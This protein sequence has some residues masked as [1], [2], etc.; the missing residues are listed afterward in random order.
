MKRIM[1]RADALKVE[2]TIAVW[3][4][5]SPE[6]CEWVTLTKVIRAGGAIYVY[7]DGGATVYLHHEGVEILTFHR[8]EMCDKLL[9]VLRALVP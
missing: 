1:M 8:D 4:C 6:L 2:M 5:S 9:D 3:A 7:W